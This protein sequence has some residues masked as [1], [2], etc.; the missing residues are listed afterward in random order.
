MEL[1][2]LGERLEGIVRE[3]HARLPRVDAQLDRLAKVEAALTAVQDAAVGLPATW[4][5]DAAI[6]DGSRP[7]VWCNSWRVAL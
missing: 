4:Q 6:G 1:E 7:A 2:G 5:D 3:R